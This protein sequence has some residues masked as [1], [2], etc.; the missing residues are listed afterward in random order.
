M[1]EFEWRISITLKQIVGIP[2]SGF[3]KVFLKGLQI[4][5]YK[6]IKQYFTD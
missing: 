1:I 5:S 3:L 2:L 4:E 6:K